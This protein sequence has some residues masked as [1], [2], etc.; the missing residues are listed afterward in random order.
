MH[1]SKFVILILA[2]SCT[3]L[4]ACDAV[5][6][7]EVHLTIGTFRGLATGNGTDR[8]LGIPYAQPPVGDLRFKAPVA[9]KQPFHAV[10][11][12]LAF[13]NACPQPVTASLGAAIAEDCLFL[14]VW[15]PQ[16][17]SSNAQLPVLIWIH[18]GVY[19]TGSASDP[20]FDGNHIVNRSVLAGKPIIF[21]SINYR[22]NTFGFLAS[23]H[24][25]AADLNNGL[26]DQ[27][28]AFTF[29]QDNIAQ[30]GGDPSKVTIWGQ[31]AGAGSV[32]AQVIFHSSRSLF[33]AAI[34][35]SAVGP[36]KN[37]P[38][39]STF[40]LPGKP[41]DLIL[42]ATGCVAGPAAFKCLQQAPFEP[43]VNFSN[44]R[45]RATL[46]NQFWEPTIAPGSFA[47]VRASTA[48]AAGDFLHIPLIAGTN[49]NEGA[50][51]SSTL[52]GLNVTSSAEDA[53]L[54]QFVE[55]SVIDQTKITADVLAEFRSLYPA[56][57]SSLGAPFNTGDSLFD[58]AAA[59]YGDFMFLASRRRF[60]QQAAPLQ[61]IY[62]YHFREFIAG[63]NPAFG[64][65][66]ASELP[67]LFGTVSPAANETDFGNTWL[68]LYINFINDLDPGAVWPQYTLDSKQLLQL[69]RDNITAINDD[70]NLEMTDYDNT[71]KVLDE[72]EK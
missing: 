4:F 10:Q 52:L 2:S 43:L 11:D 17:T 67:L 41:F 66:H 68:D 14:N 38:P 34:M 35:D 58:R 16:S 69:K 40:D 64:V 19:N 21:V 26:Q 5:A 44:S 71:A 59:W 24:V 46:N 62:S 27:R 1:L 39:P 12:A 48:I 23:V 15:R 31:S 22:L 6:N 50:S 37:S 65:A 36:F 53:A 54:D 9:I 20:S 56:N 3:V 29:V 18:G 63:N 70:F 25:P 28:A 55:A 51:F 7:P 30:F 8:W 45:I 42:N 72:W 13:G 47:P 32:E 60:F 61:P 49:L 57:D 33:R